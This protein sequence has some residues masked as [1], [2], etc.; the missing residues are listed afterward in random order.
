MIFASLPN[1]TT[2]GT[3]LVARPESRL[4]QLALSFMPGHWENHAVFGLLRI[5]DARFEAPPKERP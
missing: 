1:L 3:C 5:L 2:G 4:E